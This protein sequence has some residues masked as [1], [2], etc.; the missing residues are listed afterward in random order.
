MRL[1]IELV[2]IGSLPIRRSAETRNLSSS[3]VLFASESKL[4][5]GEA[6]EYVITLPVEPVGEQAVRLRCVGKVVRHEASASAAT[7]ERYEFLR[8]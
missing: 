8:N 2:R 5:I 6:I 7:L 4:P 3:G 1:P